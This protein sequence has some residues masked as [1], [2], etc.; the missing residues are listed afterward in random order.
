MKNAT[1][2]LFHPAD[3]G[4]NKATA[5]ANRLSF[6]PNVMS[7][8][9]YMNENT[10]TEFLYE[11]NIEFADMNEYLLVILAVDND[12]SRRA[13]INVLDQR[14]PNFVVV[15]PGNS[16][17]T[18]TCSLYIKHNGQPMTTHP[19]DRYNNLAEPSD[20]IPGGCAELTP[21]SPQLITANNMAAHA[22]LLLIGNMLDGEPVPDE[23]NGSVRRIKL[24]GSAQRVQ[25]DSFPAAQV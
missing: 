2:Q 25:L 8:E 24:V 13:I 22:A 1:R 5:T 19:F 4:F 6:A 14:V 21:S 20:N 16:F 7:L 23:I 3:T 10:F 15:N 18:A 12:A 17:D 11:T 9:G